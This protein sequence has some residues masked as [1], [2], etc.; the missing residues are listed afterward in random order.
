MIP[1]A[2]GPAPGEGF[3]S[4]VLNYVDCQ[5]QAIGL[6]GYQALAAPGSTFSL[7][8]TAMLT[9]FIALFGYRM[10]FG[11]PPGIRDGVLAAIKI[12]IVFTLA[13]SWPVYRTLLYDVALKA[14]AEV[15]AEIGRPA[16][17]PGAGGGLTAR[18]D[19]ADRA[20][21]ALGLL[22]TGSGPPATVV[23]APPG[24]PQ[25]TASAF[26]PFALGGARIMYLA[27]ALGTLAG[28]RL[29][30]GLMLALGPIFIAFLLFQSTRGLFE[31]WIRVL[32]GAALGAL[33]T[34]ILL[35]IQ[36]AFIEPRLAELLAWRSA[37]Y[38]IPGAPVELFV[39]SLVF[40]LAN[41]AILIA[42]WRLSG[43]FGFPALWSLPA[44]L[45]EAARAQ[46]VRVP[47]VQAE[48][49][50]AAGSIDRSRAAA[51][52]EFVAAA[53]RRETVREGTGYELAPRTAEPHVVDRERAPSIRHQPLG[54]SSRRARGRVS[55]SA[56]RRDRPR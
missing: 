11:D 20:F 52:A 7:L 10:L 17:I 29:I 22:G 55:A 4:G 36:L 28:M 42:A 49:V 47:F 15:A 5:A 51:T 9:L 50:P 56:E 8:L 12:G 43:G 14:P 45:V 48:P 53:Q 1:A 30:A 13:F 25:E 37:G 27:G 18:L 32:A 39:T 38:S 40:A 54:Q 6:G 2:C 33:G 34:A 46:D 23:A 16:R 19:Y 26:D 24:A 3:V 41:L 31:G 44:R 35:G 21:V